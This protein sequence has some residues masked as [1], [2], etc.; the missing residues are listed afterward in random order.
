ML[1]KRNKLIKIA[2]RSE[3]GWK[4]VEEYESDNLAED[5]ADEKRIRAA[6]KAASAKKAQQ[7]E[8]K[9]QTEKQKVTA[10]PTPSSRVHTTQHP[11]RRDNH[12]ST[13]TGSSQPTHGDPTTPKGPRRAFGA[14]TLPPRTAISTASA[15]ARGDTCGLR[16]DCPY[17]GLR[18]SLL[19]VSILHSLQAARQ[20]SPFFFSFPFLDIPGS[21]ED[22]ATT[23]TTGDTQ[24]R[25]T[26]FARTGN[27][28][29]GRSQPK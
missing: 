12:I 16:R 19:R 29:G 11:Q 2:D 22:T 13:R 5:S 8:E 21:P 9:A 6:K 7:E 24:E 1:A 17:R 28:S 26:P 18:P 27:Q 20:V 10:K 25:L 3:M 15:A 4:T 14:I 23:G